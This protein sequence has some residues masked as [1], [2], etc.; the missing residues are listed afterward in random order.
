MKKIAIT[1]IAIITITTICF[2]S[3]YAATDD[4]W[5]I[6]SGITSQEQQFN[7]LMND[8]TSTITSDENEKTLQET[9]KNN[10]SSGDSSFIL[11]AKALSVIPLIIN[12]MLA[13]VAFND[14]TT[15]NVDGKSKSVFTIEGL[16]TNQYP[17]FNIDLFS[18]TPNGPNSKFSNDIKQSAAVWY[19][20]IRNIALVGMVISLIYVA[21]RMAIATVAEEKAKYK[22]MLTSWFIGLV[23]IFVIHYIIIIMLRLSSEFIDFIK[24]AIE[25]DTSTSGMEKDIL[26]NLWNT[27]NKTDGAQKI[28]IVILYMV[29]TYYELKFFIMYMFRVFKVFILTI[30]APIISLTYPID[31]IGDGRAQAF[32][33]W[34][35]MIMMEIFVQPIQLVIYIIFVYSASEIA[36]T[37]PIIGIIFIIALDNG[38]KIIRKA[39]KIEG[40]PQLKD[41]KLMRKGK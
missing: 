25:T 19:V 33:H 40:G 38:E 39:L 18:E 16:L 2:S 1:L 24:T 11:V 29:L 7:S 37:V 34:L 14:Q 6:P 9:I 32:N 8:G 23:L 27:L 5:V 10:E 20:S 12:K 13:L 15:M 17:I 30:I 35:R 3:I 28:Y 36:K 31:T 41:I 22:K 4:N 26:G 21:I